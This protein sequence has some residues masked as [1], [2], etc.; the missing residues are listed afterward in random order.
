[1]GMVATATIYVIDP[2][3]AAWSFCNEDFHWH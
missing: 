2:C 3:V 1:M